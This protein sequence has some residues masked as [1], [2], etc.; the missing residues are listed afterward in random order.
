VLLERALALSRPIRF[1]GHLE[2]DLAYVLSWTDPARSMAIADAAAENA[3]NAG[4]ETAEALARVMA[5]VVRVSSDPD[6]S[7]N[8]LER[9][10]CTA[11]PLLEQAEDHAG[12]AYVWF[13]L[14]WSVA[15]M[16]GR[17]E[18]HADASERAL[19][20]AHLAGQPRGHLFHLDGALAFGPRPADEA[21]ETLEAAVG[22]GRYPHAQ[23]A[24]AYLLALLGRFDE[25]WEVGREQAELLREMTG[26]GHEAWLAWIAR[27]EGDEKSAVEYLRVYCESLR[28]QGQAGALSTFAP[29][30]A[31]SL[32][33][34]G[35]YDQ[36]ETWARL[37]RELANEQDA[38][39][40][41]L[42]RQAQARIWAARGELGEAERLAREAVTVAEQM[43]ALNHQG[44]A[45]CDLAEVLSA[46]GRTDEARGALEQAL[47]RYE[48]KKNLV[49]AERVRE[50]L[51][52]PTARR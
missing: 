11:L 19:H 16:R 36:A 39:S 22:D 45:L 9:R 43:D 34:L 32:C 37:G 33:A 7:V 41:A 23:L 35:R 48:R 50:Q 31:R 40:Q 46:A 1:D 38:S 18:D 15:N 25:A 2:V 3:R 27:L 42:W 51:A 17:F 20:H 8:E 47:N 6:A 14:G 44:D 13:A 29:E 52:R 28:E 30:L 24:R 26:S 12:L 4:L 21:L 49:M 5:A 10:A